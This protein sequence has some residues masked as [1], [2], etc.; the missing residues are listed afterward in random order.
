MNLPERDGRAPS[1]L[2]NSL[3]TTSRGMGTSDADA[4]ATI[5]KNF[6]DHRLSSAVITIFG[7]AGDLTKRLIV[8][9]LYNLVRGGKLPE[10]FAIIG[11]DH[12]DETTEA[13][14]QSLA[15]M[16]QAFARSSDRKP[17]EA[18]DE[19]AWSWLIR[20]M[21]Y[22]RGDFTKPETYRRLGE[23]LSDQFGRQDGAANALFYLAVADRFFGPIIEQ[24]GRSAHPGGRTCLG[25]E[26]SL[27]RCS[28]A[29]P[30]SLLEPFPKA[31]A[32][33]PPAARC[34]RPAPRWRWP[35]WAGKSM[36]SAGSAASENLKSTIRPPTAGAAAP[37]FH[38]RCITQRQWA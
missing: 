2:R 33:G 3:S 37:P 10:G 34:P 35:R 19:Q 36:W 23:L 1:P 30:C 21:R 28:S 25:S 26:L 29:V 20:R 31:S 5:A 6:R 27:Q 14:R 22:M 16:M 15:E 4:A 13:W 32:V 11:V 18:I 17:G 38:V 9:A 8:P 7:A 12:N 24:L